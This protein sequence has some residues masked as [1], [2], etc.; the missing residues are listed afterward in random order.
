M[1]PVQSGRSENIKC[2]EQS[3]PEFPD[4]LFGTTIDGI[5]YFDATHY[6]QKQEGSKS[7][8]PEQAYER[9]KEF[10]FSYSIQILALAQT[11]GIEQRSIFAT[12]SDGHQ[13]IESSFVYLFIAFNDPNFLG[14][15]NER[16]HEM[17]TKGVCLSDTYLYGTMKERFTPE[18]I[19]EMAG[20]GEAV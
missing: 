6:L 18:V 3:F 7:C 1:E 14:Y 4:L 11:Y 9:V 2:K 8:T 15:M 17:F 10:M 5:T 20:D 19:R 13:L 12:N 16:I